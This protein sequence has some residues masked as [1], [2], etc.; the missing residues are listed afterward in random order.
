M[1]QSAPGAKPRIVR[2][3]SSLHLLDLARRL[4]L[5][6]RTQDVELRHVAEVHRQEARGL[7]VA[8]LALRRGQEHWP[9]PLPRPP[10]LLRPRPV[11]LGG[12]ATSVSRQRRLARN[13]VALGDTRSLTPSPAERLQSRSRLPALGSTASFATGTVSL[14]GAGTLPAASL[15]DARR[16]RRASSRGRARSLGLALRLDRA[17]LS[18]SILPLL[19]LCPFRVLSSPA[20][21]N[22]TLWTLF[23]L[24]GPSSEKYS[25][26][27]RAAHAHRVRRWMHRPRRL[28]AHRPRTARYV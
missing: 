15:D 25:G 23:W 5:L 26:F 17:A 21:P 20:A 19:L 14:A 24:Y 22:S 18:A 4:E 28:V 1:I 27:R 8:A 9:R 2:Q 11:V 13:L 12:V 3:R 16:H 7:V 6:L 10:P